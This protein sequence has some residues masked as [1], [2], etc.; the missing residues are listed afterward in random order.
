M[1]VVLSPPTAHANCNNAAPGS[2]QTVTCDAAAPNPDT[3]GVNAVA[4]ST[5]VTINVTAGASVAVQ[6]STTPTALSVIGSSQITNGGVINLSGGGGSGG[7][8]GAGMVGMADGN[9]LT[10]SGTIGTTG[11]F[12]DGMAANGSNNV[13]MNNGTITTVGSNAYGMTAAWGQTNVGQT[14]NNLTNNGSVTTSG[15]DARAASILGGNGTVTNTGSL[16]TN[17][18]GSTAVYMQGNNDTL[19]NSGTIRTTGAGA[20]GVFSNTLSSTFTAQIQN[21]SGGQIISDNGSALRTLNGNTTITNAGL[22]QSGAGVALNG[23]NSTTS[24]ITMILQTGSQ[25]VGSVN[26]GAGN[27]QVRLQGSGLVDNAFTRFQTLIMQGTDWTWNGSG[28]FANTFVDTGILRLQSSLTGNATVAPGATLEASAQTLNPTVTNNG[29]LRFA[30]PGA[31]TYTGTISGTGVVEKTGAGVLTLAPV[32]AGG[33]TYSGGTIFT[34]GTVAVGADNALGAPTGALTFNGGTLQFANSFDLAAT[35]P[36][37]LTAAGGTIDTQGF[38]TTIAQGVTGTGALTKL[39]SGILTMNGNNP[40]GGGTNVTAGTLI[41]GDAAHPAA[42]LSGGG[43]VNV[44][45]GATLGGYGSVSGTVVNNGTIA[46]ANAALAGGPIG[47]FTINGTLLNS[48][49]VDLA[50]SGVGNSLTVAGNYVG[51]NGQLLVNT[52]LGPDNSASDKLVVSGGSATGTTGITVNNV[53]GTGAA[54][55]A[56]GILVIQAVNGAT[57]AGNAFSLSRSVS[58]GAY[59]YLLFK[60]GVSSGTGDNW[61]LRSTVVAGPTAAPGSPP[62]PTPGPDGKPI[63]L[64]RPEVPLYSAIPPTIRQLGLAALGTFHERR[65]EQ[66]FI[67]RAGLPSAAWARVFGQHMEQK[68]GQDTS[69]SLS[70][71]I[72]GVQAGLDLFARGTAGEHRDQLGLFFG[73]SALNGTVNGFAIGQEDVAVGSLSINGYSLGAYWTHIGPSNWYTDLVLMNTWVNANPLSARNIGTTSTGNIITAS[74]EAGYPIA[75]ASYLVLEP[76]VQAIWQHLSL[77][78]S[79]DRIST[80]GFGETDTAAGRLGVRLQGNI[81]T[82]KGLVQP[83]V[84]TNL[85]YGSAAT[86]N[87]TFASTDVIP[88]AVQNTTSFEVRAGLSAT[89]SKFA[90]IYASVG[91]A[92]ELTGDYGK[93]VKGRLGVRMTW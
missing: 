41:V 27:N 60:G 46:A 15:S 39:G 73:Y 6:R 53:G 67:T 90:N 64:F 29:L 44:A 51:N 52:V 55:R 47:N 45:A 31:G 50:G 22:I 76:Q 10:N 34:A 9:T 35:R 42:A 4:G 85:W 5:N 78:S 87:V 93:A 70:A 71:N 88:T 92:T 86:D 56:D 17:G 3:T 26:G 48:S 79:Q 12:N 43:P 38:S 25:I 11:A 68:W 8:R 81:E 23:G 75:L 14:N 30:Q 28:D 66:S 1:A 2:G 80:I 54:S 32:A 49:I 16:T 62:L 37:T 33:N 21:L 7:N 61:Y 84:T 69:P 83:F 91:Y 36:I 24:S 58:A 82:D 18:N 74:L 20:E 40:Y 13:L 77:A 89:L 72:A 57:T 19:I 63:P 65:G 59:E